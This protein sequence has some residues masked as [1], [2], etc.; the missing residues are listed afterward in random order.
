[1]ALI[2]FTTK[3]NIINP[4][5]IIKLVFQ[6]PKT[7]VNS[8]KIHNYLSKIDSIVIHGF[9]IFHKLLSFKFYQ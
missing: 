4:I 1:M 8:H 9:Q 6:I 5:Y 3:I 2:N 7:N